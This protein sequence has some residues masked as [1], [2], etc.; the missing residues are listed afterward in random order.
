[1]CCYMNLIKGPFESRQ[2]ATHTAHSTHT[3]TH[4][5]NER[6]HTWVLTP[7]NE[8]THNCKGFNFNKFTL[9]AVSVS[10]GL[11]VLAAGVHKCT[12]VCA[13]KRVSLSTR[14]ESSVCVC[15]LEN[16]MQIVVNGDMKKWSTAFRN[17]TLIAMHDMSGQPQSQHQALLYPTYFALLMPTFV[18]HLFTWPHLG[19]AGFAGSVGGAN[20]CQ[21][22]ALP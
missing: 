13:T 18:L 20:F 8:V 22:N 5:Y 19:S 15:V 21:L 2:Q 3:H 1:M 14:L 9:P 17:Q 6:A 11:S 12:Q 7:I 10:V 4:V 16:C